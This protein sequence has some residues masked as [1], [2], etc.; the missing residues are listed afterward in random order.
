M[1]NLQTILLTGASGTVG[2]EVLRQL[3][4]MNEV[5]LIV[6][7]KKTQR[8][9]KLLNPY[10]NQIEIIYGDISRK[11]D[12]K[13]LPHNIDVVI[14]L[15]AIIPPLADE[16]LDLAQAVNVEGTKLLITQ[17]ENTSPDAFFLYSSSISV[18]GDRVSNPE[19]S[20][21]DPLLPSVGDAYARTK[22]EAEELIQKSKLDWSIFRL[23]AIMKN[24]K[25]SKLMFHMPLNTL[26]EI[27]TPTDTARA[28][29]EAINKR[30]ILSKRIFNLG[31]GE[32]CTITYK[33]FLEKS[34]QLF[35]LGDLNFPPNSFALGNFHCGVYN[36]GD[37][38]ENILHFRKDTL[39]SYFAETK[40]SISFFTK[41]ACTLFRVFIK[42]ALVKQS[43]P[44]QAFN[45]NNKNMLLQFFMKSDLS[46][47]T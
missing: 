3:V 20:I 2:I 37:V 42:K 24:H 21:H 46:L 31:G 1:K 19:I 25:I 8:T 12:I 41:I 36:D 23:T 16:N 47:R 5:R 44:L 17:L 39:D 45:T 22:I 13:Q 43:E 28:F 29:I 38:L 9:K 34:F 4:L 15:A 7:D 32:N 6:F 30:S 11:E 27:C 35:G 14:H 10:K 40:H 26:L 18:Y 33:Q